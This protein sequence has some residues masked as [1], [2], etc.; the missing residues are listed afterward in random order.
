MRLRTFL[1]SY[2]VV[3]SI[4]FALVAVISLYSSQNQLS[5]LR[6]QS[7][8]EYRSLANSLQGNAQIIVAIGDEG[9]VDRLIHHYVTFYAEQ[10]IELTINPAANL[11]NGETE[12][13]IQVS[14]VEHNQNHIIHANGIVATAL[15]DFYVE[16]ILMSVMLSQ[17]YTGYSMHS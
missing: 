12:Q 15:Q 2:A 17:I 7:I 13:K 1:I 5:T 4:L 16:L 6:E 11:P 3:A 9:L 14:F 8:R 10:G